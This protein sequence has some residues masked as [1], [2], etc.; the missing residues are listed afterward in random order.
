MPEQTRPW[1]NNATSCVIGCPYPT[2]ANT[3]DAFIADPTRSRDRSKSELD[4]GQAKI[5]YEDEQKDEPTAGQLRQPSAKGAT[6]DVAR[7]RGEVTNFITKRM[8]R[9]LQDKLERYFP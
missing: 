7:E 3:F 1:T 9:A 6:A 4:H 2:T 8:H 5:R